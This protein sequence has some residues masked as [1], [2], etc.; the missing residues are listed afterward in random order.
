[1]KKTQRKNNAVVTKPRLTFIRRAGKWVWRKK[2]WI[3]ILAAIV[4]GISALFG[5]GTQKVEPLATMEITRGEMRQV[6]TATGEIQPLNTVSVGSQV[7]GTIEKL[8]VDFNSKVKKGD[9]LLEI[10]PSVL[11]ASVD[12]AKASLVSAQSQ[13]NYA[14]SEYQ[15]NKTL[16]NEGFI[17]CA[18]M[19][20][21]QTTYEQAEQSVKRMQSQ[22][23]RAVTNLGYATITSPVDGTVIAREVDVG[24]TVAASFQ[25]PN[26]FKI[27]EDLSQMQIETS[28]SEADI[29][30][31]KEGQ[32]VTFTV[33]AYPNQTF[34]GTVRQIRLSPTTTSNVVVYTVVIDVDNSDLRLMPGMTA[35]VTIVVTEKHDVFKVQNAALVLRKFDGIVDNAGD[36][37]PN[38]H[39]AIQRD[40]KV[41]LIPYTKGLVTATETEIIS[42]EL[43]DGDRVVIGRTGQKTANTTNRMG[44]PG[45]GRPM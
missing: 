2:W 40:G 22:Y 32:A 6:V 27:A 25:T 18:E 17:S 5:G 9:V 33:D 42:D 11:Q 41:I 39:L 16:Y 37:T 19:E 20:Q 14:K 23:D 44:G 31:I 29:G 8:Y 15:R 35:F 38:D 34:D 12:E 7:S 24:Q 10:E 28:V 45:G 30:V 13:R 43:R 21:S 1:M 4:W 26:L 36:A 3:M